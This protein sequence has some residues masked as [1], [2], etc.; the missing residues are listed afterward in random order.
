MLSWFLDCIKSKVT[1][2]P[3]MLARC[4]GECECEAQDPWWNSNQ[5]NCLG[6]LA[7][8]VDNSVVLTK[9]ISILFFENSSF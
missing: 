6:V 7:K 4:S 3:C 9:Y 5:G 8:G 1:D 2:N